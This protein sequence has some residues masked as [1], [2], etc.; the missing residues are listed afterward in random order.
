M[1]MPETTIDK[2]NC[3][4]FGKNCIRFAGIAFV[5]FSISKAP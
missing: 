2:D 4:I 5:I 3:S 1:R